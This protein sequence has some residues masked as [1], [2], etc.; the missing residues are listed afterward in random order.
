MFSFLSGR[1]LGIELLGRII[2]LFLTSKKL[3]KC[4]PK[5]L[6]YFTFPSGM[7]ER[8]SFSTSLPR[9]V[10][11]IFCPLNCLGTFAK[12]KQ[13]LYVDFQFYYTTLVYVS[14]FQCH[15]VLI[16]KV[17]QEVLKLQCVSSPN[18]FF[19]KIVL[20]ILDPLYFPINLRISIAISAKRTSRI[21]IS[22]ALNS[23]INQGN[24]TMLTISF[25]VNFLGFSVYRIMSSMNKDSFTS[26][27]VQM[28]IF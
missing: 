1:Y 10:Q 18:L 16:T 15:V 8:S 23:Q 14:K 5:W 20:P 4:S 11:N 22:I 26:F 24:I 3:P 17:L 12:N 13:T 25:F 9:L 28:L 27:P 2:T 6:Q 19:F 21:L 7:Y